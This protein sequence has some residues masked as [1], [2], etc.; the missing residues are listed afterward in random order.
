MPQWHQQPVLPQQQVRVL[1][2]TQLPDAIQ[3]IFK[4]EFIDLLIYN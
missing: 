1:N 3:V 2:P 4:Y